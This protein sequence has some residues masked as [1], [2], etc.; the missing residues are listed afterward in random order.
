LYNGSYINSTQP[1]YNLQVGDANNGSYDCFLFTNNLTVQ[2]NVSVVYK[3]GYVRE[4]DLAGLQLTVGGNFTNDDIFTH[5]NGTVVFNDAAKTSIISG[6]GTITFNTL[7]CL[8]ANKTVK[9]QQG[10]T[11]TVSSFDF[12]GASGQLITLDTDTGSG[13]F[14]LSDTTG[15]N[16]VEY[17]HIYRSVATGGATWLAYTTDGNVDGGGNSGWV[18][19]TGVPFD[20]LMLA[21]D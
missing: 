14:T 7:R 8:T 11:I 17:C 3:S 10:K 5:N 2:N 9:F 6:T 1:L 20:P 21:G 16:Q 19:S 15:T 18:F 13:T 4:L 12:T